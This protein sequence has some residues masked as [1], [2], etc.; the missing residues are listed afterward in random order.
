MKLHISPMKLLA[1]LLGPLSL[2][3]SA[4]A[5]GTDFSPGELVL[6]TPALHGLSS[7]S[8]GV[9]RIDPVTG[10]VTPVVDFQGSTQSVRGSLAYDPYRDQLLFVGSL[11]PAEP[12]KLFA[13]D[14][15]G[16]LIDLGFHNTTLSLITPASGGRVYMLESSASTGLRYLDKNNAMQTVMDASGSQAFVA[17]TWSISVMLYDPGTNSLLMVT[18]SGSPWNCG[19]VINSNVHR[20]QLSADGSRVTSEESC[21]SI[22]A[23]SSGSNGPVGISRTPAGEAL[24]VIDTNSNATQPRMQLIDPVSGTAGPFASNGYAG[25]AATNAGT[26]SSALGRAVILDTGN[27]LLR[28]FGLGESGAGTLIIPSSQISA[29]GSSGE[30]ATLIEIPVQSTAG[31]L[32]IYCSA[33]LSSS[34][35]LPSISG[36][37]NPSATQPTGFFV[38]ASQIEAQRF[39]LLFYGQSGSSSAPFL[40]GTLCVAPPIQRTIAV[41]SGAAAPCSGTYSFDFNA[42]VASGVDPSLVPGSV[43]H[44]QYWF[45]DP[46]DAFGIGLTDALQITLAP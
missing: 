36:L 23:D 43:V 35:C 29:A 20:L 26:Y 28:S 19:P 2:L 13:Y 7:G 46:A 40:G 1:V 4:S 16:N 39:G 3:A 41:S 8:G 38:N 24:I 5:R 31:L 33:K 6:Y 17:P 44:A 22:G 14:G 42:H 18:P 32:G 9:V 34:G 37:G 45:R 10:I 11:S 21:L 27:D 25:A 30:S 12:K 15:S